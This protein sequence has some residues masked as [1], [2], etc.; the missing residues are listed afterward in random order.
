MVR[1][2]CLVVWSALQSVPHST[3]FVTM[4]LRR[5]LRLAT[6][7]LSCLLAMSFSSVPAF[8]QFDA[9]QKGEIT[10][11]Q[12]HRLRAIQLIEKAAADD[13]Q[14]RSLLYQ[15]LPTI[16]DYE[17]VVEFADAR[18]VPTSN[19]AYLE[20]LAN[21]K[22][23]ERLPA[24]DAIVEL[25]KTRQIVILNEA[26]DTPEH[27]M[28]GMQ[29]AEALKKEGFEYLA[30]ET[31]FHPKGE[32]GI[33]DLKYPSLTTGAY[34]KEPIYADFVRQAIRI[35]FKL[36]AYE[37]DSEQRKH[38]DRSDT[39]SSI[40]VREEAQANN[41]IDNI[42]SKDPDAKIFIYVGYSHAT[43][44]WRTLDDGRELGWLAARL[45]RKTGIDPL[46]IDQ[47]GGTYNIKTGNVDAVYKMLHEKKPFETP[48][49][50]KTQDGEWLTSDQYHGKIDV[51]LFLPLQTTVNDR[52]TWLIANDY[53]QSMQISNDKY[54]QG[55]KT[56]LQAFVENEPK[57]AIPVD[58]ILIDSA[59]GHS[60][61][62]LPPGNYR[63][64][65]DLED[66]STK[67]LGSLQVEK[68]SR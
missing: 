38:I 64:V 50:V 22:E 56:L 24:F 26:H 52:P 31:L 42:L 39:Y 54:Y 2:L 10:L 65:A 62:M 16:S 13:E 37:I 43:E 58:Q 45:Q 47:V 28:V 9:L 63:L 68:G 53:R 60:Y 59:E 21:E 14:L 15:Y 4:R 61:L 49:I 20:Q 55:Q 11:S 67:E 41:L 7:F 18:Q 34:T 12:G 44:D 17:P 5:R 30:I 3:G 33:V 35:G 29:L 40:L 8:G 36:V 51:T 27:R 32:S 25:A 23:L 1:K 19:E 46:T 57:D 6:L 48:T 66:A